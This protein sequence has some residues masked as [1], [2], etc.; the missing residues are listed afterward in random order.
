MENIA[1]YFKLEE[2]YETYYDNNAFCVYGVLN[3]EFYIAHLYV[4][5]R[6]KSYSFF[7]EVKELAREKG[8]KIISGNIDINEHNKDDYTKKVL[9]HLKH[10]YKIVNVGPNRI[11]VIYEL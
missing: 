1:N 11:T 9:V 4:K 3:D 2:G 7:K 5:D 8:C 6:T 10:G